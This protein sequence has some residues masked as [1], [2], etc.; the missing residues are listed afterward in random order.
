M[1]KEI[2]L[3]FYCVSI[4]FV[5]DVASQFI[6]PNGIKRA[7]PSLISSEVSRDEILSET[8][9]F[10][11]LKSSCIAFRTSILKYISQ[12]K[13]NINHFLGYLINTKMI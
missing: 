12:F 5:K 9:I 3:L 8:E 4:F 10:H 7:Q 1:L 11:P 6:F 13:K 2:S